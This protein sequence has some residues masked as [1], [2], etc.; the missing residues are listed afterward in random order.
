MKKYYRV[1]NKETLQGLW[2]TINGSFTGFIHDKF[3]FS[4]TQ[5][6]KWILTLNL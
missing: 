1:C 5:N 2:Y 3:S 4:V 6:L